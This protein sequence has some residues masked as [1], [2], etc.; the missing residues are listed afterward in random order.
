[1]RSSPPVR[2]PKL[3]LTVEQPLTGDAETHQKMIPTS[4]DK[5]EAAA[6]QEEG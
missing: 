5:E 3:Q 6:R 1:M 4:K 2:I